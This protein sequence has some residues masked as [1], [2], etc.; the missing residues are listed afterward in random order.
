MSRV[1]LRNAVSALWFIA[2]TLKINQWQVVEITV[3]ADTFFCP[4]FGSAHQ[5][6]RTVQKF[7]F[8]HCLV[9]IPVS[10]QYSFISIFGARERQKMNCLRELYFCD[11]INLSLP[12]RWPPF[13][14]SSILLF[15]HQHAM[16]CT[17][18]WSAIL[19]KVCFFVN[20]W[21]E[22]FCYTDCLGNYD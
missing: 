2:K 9:W 8:M 13:F 10:V 18:H 4:W 14:S 7:L 17:F 3:S 21:V 5:C 16:K 15:R 6:H 11:R 19:F 20:C 12:V 1:L 22:I